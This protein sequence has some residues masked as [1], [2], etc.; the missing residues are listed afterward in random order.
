[1]AGD[2]QRIEPFKAYHSWADGH[3]LHPE[4]DLLQSISE[5]GYEGFSFWNGTNGVG[6]PL[7][8]TNHILQGRWTEDQELWVALK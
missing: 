7:D 6:N 2:I 1:M 8:V 3:F 4:A 5:L